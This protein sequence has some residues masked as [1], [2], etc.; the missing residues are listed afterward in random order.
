M[1]SDSPTPLRRGKVLASRGRP[2]ICPQLLA[3]SYFRVART[4]GITPPLGFTCPLEEAPG[5]RARYG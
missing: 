1:T 4:L 3:T 5:V 2:R